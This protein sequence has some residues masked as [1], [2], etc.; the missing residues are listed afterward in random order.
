MLFTNVSDIAL[1]PLAETPLFTPAMDGLDQTKAAPAVRLVGVYPNSVLLH[2]GD[3]A[4]VDDN[5]GVG[6]TRTTTENEFELVHPFAETAY[7]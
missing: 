6:F 2:I 7:T 4:K 5:L 3:G 1:L